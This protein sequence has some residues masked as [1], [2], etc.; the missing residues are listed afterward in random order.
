M[1]EVDCAIVARAEGAEAFAQVFGVGCDVAHEP[2]R[3][4]SLR[5]TKLT[6][7]TTPLMLLA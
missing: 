1:P 4:S 5:T 3:A 6:T 7:R 2:R